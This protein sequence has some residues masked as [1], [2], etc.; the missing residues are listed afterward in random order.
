MA[1]QHTRILHTISDFDSAP[2]ELRDTTSLLGS[3]ERDLTTREGRLKQLVK[4]RWVIAFIWVHE[5]EGAYVLIACK[6]LR[7]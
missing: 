2:S 5:L 4:N 1:K 3:L 6:G 7:T